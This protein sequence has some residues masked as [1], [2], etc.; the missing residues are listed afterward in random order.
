MVQDHGSCAGE[1]LGWKPSS[2]NSICHNNSLSAC[3]INTSS[4]CFPNKTII[5]SIDTIPASYILPPGRFGSGHCAARGIKQFLTEGLATHESADYCVDIFFFI[6]TTLFV[7]EGLRMNVFHDVSW[8]HQHEHS[9]DP[10]PFTL[11]H[12]TDNVTSVLHG[13]S[14]NGLINRS[15]QMSD[16][17]TNSNI[18]TTMC[19]DPA[20]YCDPSMSPTRVGPCSCS[21]NELIY[22]SIQMPEF[23]SNISTA[24]CLDAPVSSVPCEPSVLSVSRTKPVQHEQL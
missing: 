5:S 3:S 1:N 4:A 23:S 19:I 2:D 21:N 8:I 18:S 12:M 17:P 16:L 13:S 14:E 15:T 6:P 20:V 7:L 9:S 11:S 10:P 22:R 24:P